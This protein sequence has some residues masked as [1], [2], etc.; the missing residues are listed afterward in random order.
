MSMGWTTAETFSVTELGYFEDT[1]LVKPYFSA[2]VKLKYFNKP[3]SEV[4]LMSI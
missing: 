2:K 1:N 3:A 4:N